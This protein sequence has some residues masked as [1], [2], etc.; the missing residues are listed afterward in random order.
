MQCSV[1]KYRR[2]ESRVCEVQH[3]N[4]ISFPLCTHRLSFLSIQDLSGCSSVGVSLA[5][6]LWSGPDLWG[7]FKGWHRES[8]VHDPAQRAGAATSDEGQSVR[9]WWRRRRCGFDL[10]TVGLH[11][12]LVLMAVYVSSLIAP[13]HCTT[14][15]CTPHYLASIHQSHFLN[16]ELHR[17]KQKRAEH[18]R[19][20]HSTVE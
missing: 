8:K 20:E 7:C 5:W 15:H 16:G 2:E 14:L 12:L 6:H 1:V 18:C 11:L 9:K 3:R 10:S 13:L 17:S 4:A 19:K